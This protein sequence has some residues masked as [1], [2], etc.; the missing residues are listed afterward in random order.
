M[1]FFSSIGKVAGLLAAPVTGGASLALT[2]LGIGADFA[3]GLLANSASSRE[4]SA[5]RGFQEQLS[6]TS[7]QRAVADLR[8]AGLNPALAYSQG[9]ASTPSGSTFTGHQNPASGLGSKAAQLIQLENTQMNTALQ[10]TQVDKTLADAHAAS[11]SAAVDGARAVRQN[12]ENEAY[13]TIPPKVRGYAA[14]AGATLN[15]LR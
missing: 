8:A 6:N 14:A 15:T 5:N 7:Y 11:A 3:G 2:G 1:G 12:L 9:G 13:A 10:R 4:A